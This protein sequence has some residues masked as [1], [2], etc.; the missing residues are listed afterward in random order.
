MAVRGERP[1][2]VL[3][4]H[5]HRGQ[6]HGPAHLGHPLGGPSRG[7]PQQGTEHLRH[8]AGKLHQ[9]MEQWRHSLGGGH[10]PGLYLADLSTDV[11][12]GPTVGAPDD[13][14]RGGVDVAQLPLDHDQDV[15][16]L[17]DSELMTALADGVDRAVRADRARCRRRGIR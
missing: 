13:V 3:A 11:Q 12:V 14:P 2:A 9:S 6:P 1:P 16:V 5:A 17:Q 7:G 8:R 15:D 4:K 10:R